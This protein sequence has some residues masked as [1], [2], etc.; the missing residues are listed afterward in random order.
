MSDE[1]F[2]IDRLIATANIPDSGDDGEY[3]VAV[4]MGLFLF[5][6]NKG[7]LRDALEALFGDGSDDD[8]LYDLFD[9]VPEATVLWP[10]WGDEVVAIED[11]RPLAAGVG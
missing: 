6:R 2:G 9:G 8:Q 3:R 10:G 1:L 4:P 7:E 11:Y 5:V